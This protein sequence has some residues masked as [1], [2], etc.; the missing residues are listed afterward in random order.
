MKKIE[1]IGGIF[2]K[3]DYLSPSYINLNNPKFIEVDDI[4]YSGLLIVDYLREQND[5]IYK[6]ILE[7]NENL[8]MSVFYEKQDS[9]KV[10][11]D[12][13]YNIG[14]TS[15]ELEKI[16]K[17]RQDSEIAAF[18][19]NDA[20]YIRRE[21]QINN[22]ELYY[23]CTYIIIFSKDK[24][25]LENRINKIEGM[26]KGQ[27]LI[28]KKAYF[29]QEQVYKACLPFMENDK[30]IKETTKR[31][32]L[33]NSIQA[34]YPFISSSI[35]D[36]EGIYIGSNMYNNTMIFLDRYDREKY[37][38]SNMCIFGASGSGKSFFTKLMIIRSH[39]FG[40]EQY[41]IDPDREYHNLAKYLK[42]TII[43]IGPASETYINILDIR[44]ESLEENQKGY[45]ATKIN[46]VLGFFNLIFGKMTEDDKAILEEK[47]IKTYKDKGINFDDKSLYKKNKFKTSKDMPILEDLYNNLEGNMK[48]K[49]T[50][51]VKGSLKFFNKYTN[52]ELDNK[53]IIADIYELGEENIKFGM[54]IFTELFW[55]KIKKERKN[56]KAIYLDE[57]WQLIGVTSNKEVASFIYKIFKTIR[58]YGGSAVAITQ[59]VSDLFSLEEGIYGKSIINN[60][61]TKAFFYLEEENIKVLEDNINISKKEKI[62]IKTLKKGECIMFIGK[63]HILA[64]I[65]A[66][67]FEKEIIGGEKY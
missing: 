25:D 3:K 34:T 7:T 43:S 66:A 16:G 42:G 1:N 4:Y 9:Y 57:I 12:L 38:N 39:L 67:D 59:D 45:L 2:N 21:M 52:V 11:K 62:E 53:L 30:I 6:N 49:L 60:S 56:K 8:Y 36:E 54:Y 51:F 61:E 18:T 19:Y 58:K 40:L 15:V 35:F 22:E 31:N 63:E 55:D 65:E 24:K 64:K 14:N 26:L 44:K 23:I 27:G 17:A 29:R 5:L 46:K 13:T 37:K 48:I 20:K 50:P 32:I 28:S 10:I 41:V 47:L 33:T